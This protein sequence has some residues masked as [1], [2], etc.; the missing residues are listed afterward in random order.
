MTLVARMK[1]TSAAGCSGS[2]GKEDHYGRRIPNVNVNRVSRRRG[3]ALSAVA[4]LAIGVSAMVS[5]QT[6]QLQNL[7]ERIAE[8]RSELESLSDELDLVKTEYAEEL[9]SLATQ[10]ADVEALVNREELQVQQLE[11]EIADVESR[12]ERSSEGSID[13][14]P[15]VNELAGKLR[16]H[17]ESGIPFQRTQRL[18]ALDTISRLREDGTLG[19]QTALTRLWNL[20]DSE[21]RLLADSGLYRQP[22]V[23]NGEEKLAEVARLGMV[24]MYFRTLTG[25]V[26]YVEAQNGEYAYTVVDERQSREQIEALF[27]ALRR[28]VRQGFFPL[29]NPR[30][31]G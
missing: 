14:T 25:E 16:E 12:I 7:A 22:I 29:P 4:V 30:Y 11:R 13:V 26:G 8:R 18:N 21:F 3:K 1:T 20:V 19:D 27:E 5:A 28:N 15:V 24:L 23:L 9:R 17:V 31:D 10:S 2:D 6:E